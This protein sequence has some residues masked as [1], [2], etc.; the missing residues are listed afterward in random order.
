MTVT[1]LYERMGG[2]SFPFPATAVD[3]VKLTLE[4]LDPMVVVL[5]DLIKAAVNSELGAAWTKVTNSLGSGHRLYG[6]SPIQD[7]LAGHRPSQEIVQHRKCKFPLLAVH[8]SGKATYSRKSGTKRQK[9]Q[10]W[11][12]HYIVGLL[13]LAESWKIEQALDPGIPTVVDRVL[14]RQRHPSYAA[15]AA[16][17]GGLCASVEMVEHE[18]GQAAFGEGKDSVFHACLITL[19]TVETTDKVEGTDELT[20]SNEL[21]VN[22]VNTPEGEPLERFVVGETDPDWGGGT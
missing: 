9:T 11:E 12:V 14:D 17:F 1:S 13:D 6:T 16:Q 22:L 8:R 3:D 7:T 15:G 10:Q 19:E 2:T 21:A 18:A 4:P 20:T 5:T